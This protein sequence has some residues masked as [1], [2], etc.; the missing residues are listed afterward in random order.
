MLD[1]ATFGIGEA[2]A[3]TLEHIRTFHGADSEHHEQSASQAGGALS[4]SYRTVGGSGG[5]SDTTES[6]GC[7][8]EAARGRCNPAKRT[9][10]RVWQR[11]RRSAS[12]SLLLLPATFDANLPSSLH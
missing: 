2:Y 9:R 6:L 4:R 11:R 5:G 7:A 1:E 3:Y 8:I 12:V 10:R